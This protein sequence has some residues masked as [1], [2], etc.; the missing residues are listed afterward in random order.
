MPGKNINEGRLLE[1]DREGDVTFG[2]LEYCLCKLPVHED[3]VMIEH[4]LDTCD[5]RPKEVLFKLLLRLIQHL[6]DLLSDITAIHKTLSY[7]EDGQ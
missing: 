3:I 4:V 5:H 7:L 2:M 1:D 6:L